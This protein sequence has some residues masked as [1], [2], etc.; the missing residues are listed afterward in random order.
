MEEWTAKEFELAQQG[1]VA[2]FFYTPICGTCKLGERMLQVVEELLPAVNYKKINLNYSPELATKL[3]IQSVPCLT[4]LKNGE[5][6]KKI[7]AFQSVE[8]LY[9]ELSSI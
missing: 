2:V 3:E 4:I 5:V 6:I 8:Y 7:F 1:V 9:H